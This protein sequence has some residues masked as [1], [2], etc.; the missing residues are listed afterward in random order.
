MQWLSSEFVKELE[1][2]F[3]PDTDEIRCENYTLFSPLQ[4]VNEGYNL[5][6]LGK[7]E[8]LD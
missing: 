2:A 5:Y 4:S 7:Y 8:F 1:L 3:V 6:G